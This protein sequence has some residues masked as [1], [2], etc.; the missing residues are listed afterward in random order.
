MLTCQSKWFYDFLKFNHHAR[1]AYWEAV[2]FPK[3]ISQSLP[4]LRRH[5]AAFNFRSASFSQKKIASTGRFATMNP[6]DQSSFPGRSAGAPGGESTGSEIRNENNQN[7][8]STNK[9][10]KKT[11]H[12]FPALSLAV[13]AML[14]IFNA[15]PA[16]AA[17]MGTAFTYQGKL[18]VGT[19]AANGVYDFSFALY[20]AASGGTQ[21]GSTLAVNAVPV[22]NGL[23]T[24]LLDFGNVFPAEARWL[25]I[26]LKVTGA[27]TYTPLTSRQ[28]LTPTPYA[29]M[30][31]GA[32]LA[33]NASNVL[34]TVPAAQLSG[35][36]GNGQLANSSLTVTAGTGLSGGGAVAL[37]GSTTLNNAGVLS[38]SGNADIT[39]TPSTGT[40][41][42]GSTAT[43]ANTASRIVKRDA[44]GN[45]SAGTVTLTGNLNL[46][47]TTA[48]GGAI[49]SGG[50]LLL[51]DDSSGNFF[52][53][54]GAGNLTMSGLDNVGI[55]SY[56]LDA[57]TVGNN[58]TALG[59]SALTANTSG[60][61]NSANGEAALFSNTTGYGNTAL[62][63]WALQYNTVGVYNTA[64]GMST[65]TSN[66]NGNFNTAIGYLASD[67]NN[68]SGS[69]NLALGFGAGYYP[70]NGSY[71][72]HI[73]AYGATGDSSIIRIGMQGTQTAAY[74]AGIYGN[75]VSN[76]V[77][78]YV[79]STGQL[80][81]SATSPVALLGANET[82][83]GKTTFNPA[84]GPP[85]MVGN[86]NLVTNL[87]ADLLDGMNSTAFWSI[88]G[89][90]GTTGGVSFVG[91]TDNQPLEL[92]VNN[93]RALRLDY[94]S[95]IPSLTVNPAANSVSSYGSTIGGGYDN[96][97]QSGASYSLVGG[98]F[99]N[100]IQTNCYYSFIGG[101]YDNQI[102]V[103]GGTSA[104]A[105]VIGG[106]TA[107]II[108]AYGYYSVIAGGNGN[109]IQYNGD[110]AVIGGG[111]GNLIGTNADYSTIPGGYLNAA[112]G[113]YSLAAGRQAKANYQGDFVWADSQGV[114]FSATGYNQFLIRASGGVGLGTASPQQSLSVQG[115]LNIDQSNSNSGFINN[116]TNAAIG[117]GITFGSGS[118]EGIASKRT[119]GGNQYGLDFYT[120]FSERLSISQGGNVAINGTVGINGNAL[121][122]DGLSDTGN[123][124]Q[125][126]T[127][128]P[129]NI[130]A[131]GNGPLLFGWNGGALGSVG[132]TEVSLS[133][134]YLGNV[135]ISNNC[136]VATLTIRGGADLSEPFNL[137]DAEV[138]E[139]AVVVI[140]VHNPGHL[141]LSD[142]PYDKRVAGIVS[143]ANGVNPG[144]Q[145]HQQGILEGGKNVAL[146]GRVYVQADASNGAIEPG[147]MLTTSST[148]GHAMKV[149]DHA[150][151]A[152]AILGKAMTGLS[153]GKGLVLVLVTLQ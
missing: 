56:A 152:G 68:P 103:A 31:N 22:T 30:A 51:H 95:G 5:L 101:G 65:L 19:N 90:A 15:Q 42:L 151:A 147:D 117:Y 98:G 57:N 82:F 27:G 9:S 94:S 140:D 2:P 79:D 96:Q 4:W 66:T 71:N 14:A 38:V 130:P 70:T 145:M 29:V 132:P 16:I 81:S 50:S 52:A 73:G 46:P 3:A 40:V 114:D 131:G 93:T 112:N 36:V 59:Y 118:G 43:D 102:Q 86:S 77:P 137:T 32:S 125:Y 10:M 21:K 47:T 87:N 83:T 100:Q 108:E 128:L 105:G 20:D 111:Y 67:N 107:N 124:L 64:V 99:N 120:G 119:S 84:S 69:Y 61:N 26:S 58:N 53:G 104:Q 76:G 129:G 116:N 54:P 25:D 8:R 127:G 138:S 41:A 146:S 75:I 148:P 72:I 141:K 142:R 45:F 24:V 85:F 122:V 89:N 136:S 11:N 88:N 23:F 110:Q 143:G 134:D 6:H 153:E 39:A 92:R 44:S 106:G 109:R 28:Q 113:M 63:S 49:Y 37:G 139:G 123:G 55:G 35:P 97:I 133:W 121:L 135:W 1:L 150:K 60:N 126:F 144:I 17:P 115:G 34:G 78:V 80:G 13:A 18:N 91:T 62:G 149:D 12:Q 48:T 7:K 33:I 74:M